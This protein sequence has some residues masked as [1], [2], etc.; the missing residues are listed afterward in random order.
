VPR[1]NPISRA[2][3][4]ALFN[5]IR[6]KS[7]WDLSADL[8]WGYFF[9]G[10]DAAMLEPL[11][12]HLGKMGYDFVGYLRPSGSSNRES[13]FLHVERAETHTIDSLHRRNERLAAIAARFG[14]QYD[15]MDVGKIEQA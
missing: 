13:V 12:T 14:V 8:L 1:S 11:R 3:I 6:D 4:S 15:G 7:G 5:D 9:V 10:P 2:A